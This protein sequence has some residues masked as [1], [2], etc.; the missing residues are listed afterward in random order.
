M[1]LRG[2]MI[3]LV[4]VKENMLSIIEG[5][6]DSVEWAMADEFFNQGGLGFWSDSRYRFSTS[7]KDSILNI[8]LW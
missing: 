5:S 3:Y 2:D 6:P 1:Q 7:I 8:L 4:K